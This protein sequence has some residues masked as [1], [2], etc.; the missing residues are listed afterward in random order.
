MW[1]LILLVIITILYIIVIAVDF[2]RRRTTGTFGPSALLN[3]PLLADLDLVTTLPFQPCYNAF[4]DIQSNLWYD[5]TTDRTLT[6][7]VPYLTSGQELDIVAKDNNNN[8]VY[9]L[10][11]NGRLSC[12]PPQQ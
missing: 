6:S 9:V 7:A 3:K 4:G 1:W 8:F 2:S 5:S 10:T 12:F 11:A